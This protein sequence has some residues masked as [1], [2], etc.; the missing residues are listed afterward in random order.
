MTRMRLTSAFAAIAIAAAALVGSVPTR[1]DSDDRVPDQF[2]VDL[3]PGVN[4]AKYAKRIAEQYGG[5]A[6]VVYDKALGGFT[7]QGPERAAQRL[8]KDGRVDL[9]EQDRVV[10]AA[11]APPTDINHLNRDQVP[12]AHAAG[13]TGAGVTIAVLDSGVN[14][15]HEVF[16]DHD[17]ILPGT[18][19]C[20]GENDL[21]GNDHGNRTASN[22]V[23]RIG[24][25]HEA[26]VIPIKVF[27][28]VSLATSWTRIVCGLNYVLER[29]PEIDVVNMSI[30]GPG[31][32][33]LRRAV[34]QVVN[35]GITVVAA[36]GNNGGATQAPAR[37]AG[38]IAASA[39][40]KGD[41]MA[42]FSA[43]GDIAGPGVGVYS[44]NNS[45]YGHSSGTSRVGPQVSGVVAI[46]LA[47]DPQA[48]V[49]EVLQRSGTCPDGSTN[50]SPGPCPGRW[51]RDDAT[52]EPAI[53]AYCAGVLADP[54]RSDVA[55]CG[56]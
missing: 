19:R 49:L 11:D 34:Q 2:L 1:A 52:A 13:Y 10:R 8:A 6:T 44:A 9:V 16:R 24:V 48:N 40:A 38:V 54:V 53:N 20:V 27:P 14:V 26:K 45:G 43:S 31:S 23:G 29:A 50:G 4:A 51:R 15:Q 21:R 36:A 5:R 55:A 22:A 39:L 41:R 17:N 33:A 25:A 47:L 18:A 7:F 42:G 12:E 37:Y 32:G 35:A 28:G 30:A 46:I 3:K 56:F